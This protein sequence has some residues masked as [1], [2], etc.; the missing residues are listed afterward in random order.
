MSHQKKLMWTFL[1]C[2]LAVVVLACYVL[3]PRTKRALDEVSRDVRANIH[4]G[5]SLPEVESSLEQRRIEHSYFPGVDRSGTPNM[6]RTEAAMIRSKSTGPLGVRADIQLLF[7][8]D[9]SERLVEY[10]IQEVLTGP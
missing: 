4:T 8:F 1:G 9:E 7:R 5:M 6:T 3:R 2:A 10:S